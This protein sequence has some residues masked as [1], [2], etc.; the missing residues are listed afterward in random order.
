VTEDAAGDYY[1]ESQT[2]QD[3]KGQIDLNAARAL[4]KR[5]NGIARATD[6]GFLLVGLTAGTSRLTDR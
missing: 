6:P 4:V 1:Q 5:I 2:L 3:Q